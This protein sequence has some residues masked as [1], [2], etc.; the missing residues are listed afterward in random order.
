MYKELAKLANHLDSIN[1]KDLADRLDGVIKKA[2]MSYDVDETGAA[3]WELNPAFKRPL[4]DLLGESFKTPIDPYDF[5]NPNS[6]FNG[7]NP[8]ESLVSQWESVPDT[9]KK[10]F[11]RRY[12][13]HL[14]ANPA[15]ADRRSDEA[16]SVAAESSGDTP[17]RAIQRIIGTK[18]DG[19]WGKNTRK[20]LEIFLNNNDEWIVGGEPSDALRWGANHSSLGVRGGDLPGNYAGNY[21][22]LL[23]FVEDI[24]TQANNQANNLANLIGGGESG[25]LAKEPPV[26]EVDF[27]APD[28]LPTTIIH[29]DPPL[30]QRTSNAIDSEASTQEALINKRAEDLS[31]LF[32]IQD[33]PSVR[34]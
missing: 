13:N 26:K 23:S 9:Y 31:R 25:P 2:S 12:S 1:H 7:M 17:L 8:D 16:G 4:K 28:D 19:F 22:G 20:K 33:I 27:D 5:F 24:H 10:I 32:S 11:T 6:S 18:D 14:P 15:P 3:P 30:G 29:G 34:R 21:P